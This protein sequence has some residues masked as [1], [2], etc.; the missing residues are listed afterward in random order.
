MVINIALCRANVKR[1]K[2]KVP[3]KRLHLKSSGISR[4][5]HSD[6]YASHLLGWPGQFATVVYAGR[7]S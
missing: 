3:H 4:R 6:V 5:W 1:L 7:H 2:G